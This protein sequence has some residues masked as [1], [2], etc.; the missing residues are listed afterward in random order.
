LKVAIDLLLQLLERNP[1]KRLCMPDKIKA[2]PFFSSIDWDKL[3]RKELPPPYVPPVVIAAR[4]HIF[5]GT[6][7]TDSS[8]GFC[9][10]AICLLI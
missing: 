7:S 10:R 6:S 3:A 4:S 1:T 2:H 5:A 9:R 8:P